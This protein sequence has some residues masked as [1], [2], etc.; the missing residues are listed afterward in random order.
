MSGL[1]LRTLLPGL[2]RCLLASVICAL[3]LALSVYFGARMR[4]DDAQSFQV[5]AWFMGGVQWGLL[6]TVRT[7]HLASNMLPLRL[8]GAVRVL[9]AGCG[10]NLA[11]CLVLPLCLL[12]F[13]Q[14]SADAVLL[15]G[16]LLLGWALAML[17][18]M[19]PE[20]RLTFVLVVPLALLWV[21]AGE[22]WWPQSA[23]AYWLLAVA[24]L[25]GVALA[26]SR[27]ERAAPCWRP[28]ATV[29][30]APL[31]VSLGADQAALSS[32]GMVGAGMVRAMPPARCMVEVLGPALQSFSQFASWRNATISALFLFVC[33]GFLVWLEP[34]RGSQILLGYG[35]VAVCILMAA[36]PARY[37][38]AAQA[39]NNQSL[40]AELLLLPGLPH[41]SRW[42][43]V[44]CMQILRVL[45]ERTLILAL[46]FSLVAWDYGFPTAWLVWFALLWLVTVPVGLLQ[47]ILVCGVS[48]RPRYWLLADFAM[49]A[50]GIAS[51]HLLLGGNGSVATWLLPAWM[52]LGVLATALCVWVFRGLQVRGA[53]FFS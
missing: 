52:L 39:R 12:L 28:L 23:Y 24:A 25:I 4:G 51:S 34:D 45:L 44:L 20:S 48:Q 32:A 30:D 47:A 31:Q 36:A 26:W 38:L 53:L 41:Q 11:L 14:P 49:I 22:P 37:L 7:C 1:R 5:F 9:L 33:I 18:M 16:V 13:L 6:V 3:C 10:L 15:G 40:F 50:L 46:M 2:R 43:W 42:L 35:L 17:L 21:Y 8:P 19:M 29:F 27:L